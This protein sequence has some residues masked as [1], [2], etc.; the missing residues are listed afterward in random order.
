V[1]IFGAPPYKKIFDL[2]KFFLIFFAQNFVEKFLFIFLL[3]SFFVS[4]FPGLEQF[5]P[6]RKFLTFP[7]FGGTFFKTFF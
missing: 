5:K 1:G 6:I 4:C 7:N 2:T 3:F